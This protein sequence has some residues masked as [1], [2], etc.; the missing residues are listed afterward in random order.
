MNLSR[1]EKLK[2]VRELI[3]QSKT[4]PITYIDRFFYT[5]DP[6]IKPKSDLR[7]RLFPY[8]K[9]LVTEIKTAVETGYDIFIDKS[10]DMGATYTTLA[11]FIWFW[12][13]VP[14]SNFLIG[15]RKEDYVDNRFGNK[16]E[17]ELSNKEESLFGKIEYMLRKLPS[18]L[19]PVGF[20]FKKHNGYMKITNPENGNSIIGE[21]SNPNFSRSGRFTA[22]LLDEFAFWD[23]DTAAWGATADSSNCRIILTTP[24][25]KPGKAKRLRFGKDGEEIKVIELDHLLDPRK[26]T[27]WMEK[28]RK[29]RSEDDLAREIMRNWEGSIKG[30]V[31]EEIKY[32]TIG[33]FPYNPLWG[34]YD[35]WDFGLDGTAIG[36]WQYN[37]DNGKMRLVDAYENKDKPI[38]FYY[39][40]FN[41]PVSSKYEYQKEDLDAI[42]AVKHFKSAIHYGD[43]D[44]NKRALQ[45]EATTSTRRELE[46]VNIYVQTKPESNEFFIRR[47]KT[48]VLLQTGIEVN[49][50]PRTEHWLE[51]IKGARYPQR[52]DTSQSTSQIVKPIHDWTSHHRTQLEYLAVNFVP[53][54]NPTFIHSIK[55]QN[56]N[57]RKGWGIQ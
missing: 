56:A 6:R 4:D 22:I 26:T 33:K 14:G 37:P 32:A 27:E 21:S 35:S 5:F 41:N 46:K 2:L 40:L 36:F 13:N 23:N 17:A 11:T 29:R 45:D 9:D 52:T 19:L 51:C 57:K 18:D 49:L 43:P 31:Y 55:S 38:H 1:E 53:P 34:L 16:S 30:I 25:I 10:R 7:F 8:Q 15:S 12:K 24:G 48:K 50:T 42:E 39:P 44:V 20:D 47:E 54:L 28:Q 3:N